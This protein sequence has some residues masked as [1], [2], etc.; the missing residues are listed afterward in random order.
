[1]KPL[2]LLLI[3]PVSNAVTSLTDARK[4]PIAP[5]LGS[6]VYCDLLCGYAEHS[7]IYVGNQQIAH[8]N[9]HGCIELVSAAEFVQ[10]TTA[11]CIYV[12]AKAQSSCGE[13]AIA[14]RARAAV[15]KQYHYRLWQR[16]CHWFSASCLT[17]QQSHNTV[18]L[19]Q[20]RLLAKQKLG[21]TQWLPSNLLVRCEKQ[22]LTNDV[23]AQLGA[24]VGALAAWSLK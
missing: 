10:Q 24:A 8:M 17:G 20:L 15:G 18:L 14:T 5:A 9:R 19:T 22:V 2:L 1:M 11:R 4:Q 13:I 23:T 21:V 16:N 3:P 6:V 12:S 7:G